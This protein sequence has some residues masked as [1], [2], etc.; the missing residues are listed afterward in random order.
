MKICVRCLRFYD[1]NQH[2]T[3]IV[4]TTRHP[5]LYLKPM[6]EEALRILDD[7][8]FTSLL[9]KLGFCAVDT[10]KLDCLLLV[11]EYGLAASG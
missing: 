3:A 5:V 2:L 7:K 1:W 10:K 9:R 6:L 11:L 4:K 8:N